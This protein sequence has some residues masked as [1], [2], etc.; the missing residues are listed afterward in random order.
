VLTSDRVLA[1]VADKRAG[2]A[3]GAVAVEMEAG[4]LA[5]WA[6][7]HSVPFFHL[8][9]VLDPAASALPKTRLPTDDQGRRPARVLLWHALTHPCQWPAFWRLFQQASTTQK[10]MTRV[11]A[12]LAGPG[13][14]LKTCG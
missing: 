2:A 7:A 11:I 3:M 14:P 10:A 12:A 1:S 8:R 6:A 5:R 9:V 13:N 4:P